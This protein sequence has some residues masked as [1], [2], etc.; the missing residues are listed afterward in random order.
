MIWNID[1]SHSHVEFAVRHLA[2]STTKGRFTDF[3]GTIETDEAGVPQS[4]VVT[5]NAN[6]INTFEEARDNHLRSADF[7]EAEKYPTLKFVSTNIVHKG[8]EE[9]EITGDLTIRDH[10]EAVTLQAEIASPINDP[11]GFTRTAAT[12]KGKIN[13]KNWGLTWNQTLELGG[14][15]VGDEVKLSIEV[16]ATRAVAVAA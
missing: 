5:I 16:E 12:A 13:R 3:E 14:L 4:I 15:L 9:Y 10:T 11:F 1:T 8:A 2:I 6:S 7:F